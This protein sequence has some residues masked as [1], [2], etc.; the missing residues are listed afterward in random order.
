MSTVFTHVLQ[1]RNAVPTP[2]RSTIINVV[3]WVLLALVISI[4]I[5]RFAVKLSR[6]TGWRRIAQ[7][8]V[9][10]ISAAVR[11]IKVHIMALVTDRYQLLSFGQTIAVS[12]QW[13]DH[14]S[15]RHLQSSYN[16]PAYQKVCSAN[17][18]LI[19]CR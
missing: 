10:L 18:D 17:K 11:E 2:G 7:D 13:K 15:E 4:L 5:A 16:D 14:K 3:S 1:R 19:R 8:D 12:I 6:R 9:L